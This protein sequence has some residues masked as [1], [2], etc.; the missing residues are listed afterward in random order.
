MS[1]SLMHCVTLTLFLFLLTGCDNKH[2][3]LD[4]SVSREVLHFSSLNEITNKVASIDVEYIETEGL[5]YCFVTAPYHKGLS[6]T[7]VACYEKRSEGNWLMRCVMP[8]VV[9]DL[10]SLD[11]TITRIKYVA[12]GKSVDVQCNGGILFTINSISNVPQR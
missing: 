4:I 11:G 3:M 7:M 6:P 8:I 12:S 9:W 2:P 10:K 1:P 5:Q